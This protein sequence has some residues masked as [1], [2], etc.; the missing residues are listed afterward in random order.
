MERIFRGRTSFAVLIGAIT[1]AVA[2]CTAD[3][4]P[5]GP[6]AP[7][8]LTVPD[9]PNDLLGLLGGD[10]RDSDG[11]G[12]LDDL[13]QSLLSNLSLHSCDSP[14]LGSVRKSIGPAGGLIQ[15][16]RHSLTVPPGALPNQVVITATSRG[17]NHVRVD[18][19]PHGLRFKS[20]ATLRLSYA[21]CGS[22][23]LLPKIVYVDGVGDLLSILEL[24]LTLDN[25]GDERVTAR[26][27]HFSGYAIA[28]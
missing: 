17:G 23:P 20:R 1:I 21:H 28:D 6:A 7:P 10:D 3:S 19:E 2:A 9:A 16:G 5:T 13:V 12:D 25:A 26:L 22:R 14:D 11:E 4:A 18:F 27:S 15:I 8:P 24:T